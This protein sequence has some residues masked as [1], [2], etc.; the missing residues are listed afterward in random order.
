MI[1]LVRTELL[2]LA[3]TRMVFG[4]LGALLLI[5]A[6][7]NIVGALATP[8]NDLVGEENQ[9]GFFGAAASGII[10]VLLLGVMLMAGEFRHG[11]ITQTLLITPNRWKVLGA[12][13]LAGGLLG[14]VFGALAEL[15]SFLTAVPLIALRGIELAIG[16]EAAAL[17]LGV[18]LTTTISAMLGVSLGTLVRNQV[19][20]IILV[21]AAF[22]IIEPIVS[23]LVGRK[24]PE[25]PKYF[26]GHATNAAVDPEGEDLLSRWGGAAVLLAYVGVL[27]ALGGRFVLSRD[28]NSIQA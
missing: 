2:K 23:D 11:T 7:A 6:L 14:F 28:V 26:P 17:A 21:F 8:A 27:A 24:W 18:M 1:D 4:F 15:F 9:S 25:V 3:T 16:D 5:V 13:I 10:F 12:K 22:L 19:V 20:A